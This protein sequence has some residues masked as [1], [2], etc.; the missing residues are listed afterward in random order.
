MKVRGTTGGCSAPTRTGTEGQRVPVAKQGTLLTK[1]NNSL[2]HE[3]LAGLVRV[4]TMSL[5]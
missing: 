5:A 4:V 2:R 1:W 3:A